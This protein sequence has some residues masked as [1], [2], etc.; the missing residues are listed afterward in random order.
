MD[1]EIDYGGIFGIPSLN[2]QSK[3]FPEE[4]SSVLFS[5]LRLEELESQLVEFDHQPNTQNI[6]FNIP[7]PASES[8][9]TSPAQLPTPATDELEPESQSQQPQDA[10][11]HWNFLENFPPKEIEYQSWDAFTGGET[12]H[13]RNAYITEAGPAVFDAAVKAKEDYL[14]VKNTSHRI[15]DTKLYASCLHALGLG[16]SS[17]LFRYDEEER[18]FTP[19]LEEI[20]VSGCTEESLTGIVDMFME[21]GNI[22]RALQRF[23]NITYTTNCSAGRVALADAVSTLLATLQKELSASV[24]SQK[25]ILQ[26]KALFQPAHVILTCFRRLIINTSKARH[27]EAM[28]STVFEEIQQLEHRTDSLRAVLLEVLSSVSQPWLNF[29][30]EWL[31]IQRESGIPL[32]K[33]GEGKSFVK[34][35]NR[36]WTDE[37]GLE[38]SEPD[39]VLDIDLVPS[40]MAPDIARSMFEVGRSLRFLRE[41][42]QDLYVAK[43]EAIA[44][45]NPPSLEWKFSWQDIMHV[46][47]KAFKYERDLREAVKQYSNQTLHIKELVTISTLEQYS[48][49]GYFSKLEEDMEARLLGSL[50][51]FNQPPKDNL[52]SDVFSSLISDFIFSKTKVSQEE[53]SIFAPPISLTPILNFSPVISAQARIV[54]GTCMRL[55]F[56]SHNLREHLA[57]Q[58]SFHLLG[59]GVFSS[60]LSHALFDPELESAERRRGIARSGG[61]MGLRLGGRDTWPPASSE[62]RLALMGVLTESYMLTQQKQQSTLRPT[63]LPGDLSFAVRDMSEEEIEKCI[64]PDSIGALDFLRLSYKPPSPLEAVITPLTLYKYDQIFKLLLRV[65]RM[66]YVISALFRDATDRTSHWQEMDNVA[67][68]F[69]IEAHHF[70]SSLSGYFFDTGVAGTWRLF[71]R[72]LDQIE[73]RLKSEDYRLGEY[74]GIDQLRDYH[75]RVLDRILFALLLRKRQQPVMKLL[76][77]IFTIILRFSKYSRTRALGIIKK[78]GADDEVREMYKTFH[79]K[80]GVFIAVCK[81]LNEKKGYG[82]KRSIDK[83]S[84]ETGLFEGNDL[85]EENTITQLLT[86]ALLDPTFGAKPKPGDPSSS[87]NLIIS[88]PSIC[89]NNHRP[90]PEPLTSSNM[91]STTRLF[92]SVKSGAR[93]L[94]ANTLTGLAGLYTHPAPRSTLIYLY[95]KTLEK[96]KEIPES[97]LYRQSSEAVAKHRME[98]ISSVKPAGY[99]EWAAKAKKL[100]EEHPEVFNTPEGGIDYNK[101]QHLKEVFVGRSFV[102]TKAEEDLDEQRLEWNG[103]ADLGPEL[104]GVRTTEEKKGLSV[105]AKK[106]PGEDEK[107]VKWEPEPALTAD[108]IQEVE[109]KI[110]AGLIEEVIQV[111]EGELKLVDVMIKAKSWEDLEEKPVKGQWTYFDDRSAAPPS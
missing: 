26:L 90:Q 48:K 92:A 98:I 62:L 96:L 27:D 38:H 78:T 91:R 39:Y 70:I 63:T 19:N 73:T 102:T 24:S 34:I 110:G 104:E 49:P 33:D 45:C 22:T 65:L 7:D 16:R 64:N 89:R 108:Q 50:E 79:K 46:E 111:A 56:T 4:H 61:I 57:V 5:K 11:E 40:F 37:Q 74:E 75:E 76:E 58:R 94:E 100:L 95:S 18:S 47:A 103:E 86:R 82:E 29:A 25:S 10:E 8:T 15:I 59:N 6:F 9:Q 43:P 36:G 14:K 28:I 84:D 81:G 109:N 85:I 17:L 42:H 30:G 44:T 67:Q 77:E 107:T 55:F 99:D 20:R 1:Y 105:L 53:G 60:R 3:F 21:C 35:A 51:Q 106:R 2:I 68:R 13:Y 31:G 23:I 32:S 12:K 69:R 101:G 41:H 72:K 71:E 54:N 52:S 88:R 80:V 83:L 87:R 66:L 97:S 93:Y